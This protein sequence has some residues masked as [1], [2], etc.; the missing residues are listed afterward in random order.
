[1]EILLGT[2][3]VGLILLGIGY[4]SA[5]TAS[6][7]LTVSS[8]SAG[9][10]PTCAE[11][12]SL[13]N[14]RRATACSALAAS[15]AATAALAAANSALAGAVA[16]AAVLLAAAVATSF[17]PIFGPAIAAPLFAAY[18]VAQALVMVLWGRQIA[19]ANAA[20]AAATA[21]STAVTA[22]AAARAD[23]MARCTDQTTLTS[24]LATPSPCPGVP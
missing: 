2:G 17:I 6:S 1:M 4:A 14:T 8:G 16:A 22:A 18:A 3:V 24:C 20:S 19:F 23:L 15:T 12:C 9:P 7:T 5:G 13:W 10:N 21:A 11:L